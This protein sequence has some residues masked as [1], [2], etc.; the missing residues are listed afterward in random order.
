M[1]TTVNET[2]VA[3]APEA[4]SRAGS[5]VDA[6]DHTS[7]GVIG[8]EAPR[9]AW[10]AAVDNQAP[11]VPADGVFDRLQ[12]KYTALADAAARTEPRGICYWRAVPK[13]IR[14][15]LT[16]IAGDTSFAAA[17]GKA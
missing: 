16:H 13:A 9:A 3:L 7:N 1:P 12:R 2:S 14:A 8:H 5:A 10:Q 17:A 15:E 4:A 11:G 6:G